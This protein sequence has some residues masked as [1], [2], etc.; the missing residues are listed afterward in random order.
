M[1]HGVVVTRLQ[2]V[3]AGFGVVVVASVAQ[4]V[5]GGNVGTGGDCCAVCVGYAENFAPGI[6]AVL[7]DKGSVDIEQTDHIALQIE[8]IVVGNGVIYA[9]CVGYGEGSAGFIIG[10]IQN[11]IHLCAFLAKLFDR[12]HA[13]PPPVLLA[14]SFR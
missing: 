5:E 3:E 7:G 14:S 10:E 2:I 4:G 1:G 8:D 13:K 12:V 6:V 9:G 11:V